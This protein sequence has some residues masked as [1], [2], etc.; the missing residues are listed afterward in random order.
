MKD[1]TPSLHLCIPYFSTMPSLAQLEAL[2][3]E[4]RYQGA[5]LSQFQKL[6]FLDSKG[7]KFAPAQMRTIVFVKKG[8]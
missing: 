2:G 7:V 8:G 5:L 6:T 4:V 3:L 1:L